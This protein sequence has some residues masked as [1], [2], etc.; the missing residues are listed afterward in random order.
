M[1]GPAKFPAGY[2]EQARELAAQGHRVTLRHGS[3]E[4]ILEPSTTIV[5]NPP[6]ESGE[7]NT[8]D[9]IFGRRP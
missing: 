5:Q 2:I 9:G 4:L 1:G 8:C 6:D 7:A 3:A